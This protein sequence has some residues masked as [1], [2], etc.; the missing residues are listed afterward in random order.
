MTDKLRAT[1]K[2]GLVRS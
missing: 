1:Q 2:C